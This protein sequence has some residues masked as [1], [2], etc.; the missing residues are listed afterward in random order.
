MMDTLQ[1]RW[2]LCTNDAGDESADDLVDSAEDE[3][4]AMEE[5]KGASMAGR[6]R[7]F[8]RT[9][10]TPFTPSTPTSSSLRR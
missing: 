2:R 4:S 6:M 5:T 1:I 3:D 8:G 10:S 9:S 7:L